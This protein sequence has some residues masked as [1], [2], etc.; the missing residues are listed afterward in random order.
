[1]DVVL[2]V[3]DTFLFDRLYAS[4][5]PAQSSVS[6]FHPISTIAASWKGYTDVNSTW[7]AATRLADG[8]FAHSAWQW[9]PAS[10]YVGFQPTEYAY[11]SRWDRDN[12]FRQTLSLYALT[13]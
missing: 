3:A 4:V 5:L 1:M 2:E 8:G 12:V 11:M 7:E 9:Q 10:Q 6:S 13:W